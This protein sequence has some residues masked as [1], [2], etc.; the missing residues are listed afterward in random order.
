MGCIMN[1]VIL[2]PVYWASVSG[3]KDSL[4]ML[5]LIWENP[6]RYPLH[7]VFHIELEIDYPFIKNVIDYMEK[8]CKQRGIPFIRIHPRQTWDSLYYKLGFP[9]KLVRWCNDR[10]KLSA[11][12]DFKKYLKQF[13]EKPIQYIGF[14]ADETK[15]LKNN[16]DIYP[17]AENGITEDS[18]L[19]W[20]KNTDLFEGFY[21]I[22]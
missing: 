8:E 4:Y 3:G 12:D 6:A 22:F 9:S 16:G 15:R 18:I 7:G 2:Q 1:N 19:T 20:A 14:C 5:K 17:L 10:Y 11:L 21:K 13:N